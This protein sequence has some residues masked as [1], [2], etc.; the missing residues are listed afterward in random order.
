MT[1][2][3]GLLSLIVA[4]AA[5]LLGAHAVLRRVRTGQAHRDLLL[6]LLLRLAIVSAVVLLAGTARL[7]SPWIMGGAAALALVLLIR[8]GEHRKLPRIRKPDLSSFV[9]VFGALVA[10]RIALQV[11]FFAPHQPDTLAYHL[12]KIGEWIQHR[13]F[14]GEWGIDR[15][16]TFPSGFELVEAWWVVFLRHDVLIE[17]AGIEFLLLAGA[18]TNAM[19][20]ELGLA[21]RAAM[22]AGLFY[23]M[24]PALLLQAVTALNDGPAAALVV[25]TAALVLS[26][27]HPGL[28]LLAVG[29]GVGVKPTYG[30]AL[31]GILLLHVLLPRPSEEKSR[32][33]RWAASAGAAGLAI[34][35]SWY[36][37]NLLQF[38]NPIHP[39]GTEGMQALTGKTL[40]RL[41][42]SLDSLVQNLRRLV[43]TRI[44]DSTLP[45]GAQC[46]MISGWGAV[47][48]ALG[49]VALVLVLREDRRLRQAAIGFGAALVCVLLLVQSDPWYLR[50]TL[51]FPALLAVAV[52]RLLEGCPR[53]ALVTMAALLAQFLGTF[54]PGEMPVGGVRTLAEMGWRV[55]SLDSSPPVETPGDVVGCYG[56]DAIRAYPLYRADFSRR[57]VY[58]RAGSADELMA[59]M[60]RE[61]VRVLLANRVDAAI[62]EAVS[63]GRLR[64]TVGSFYERP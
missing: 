42:P 52:A 58:L 20:R 3:L 8:E 31:P 59:A 4:N 30:Y 57:V 2:M 62:T 33:S 44:Y 26:R 7:F 40:Q 25:A 37:R 48:F 22:W 12:P 53:T 45:Y 16:S 29:L 11:W 46:D 10:L 41:G 60:E 38:G 35:A 13:G 15:R 36:V 50:F 17:M 27:A 49:T 28:I 21:P 51:F 55:R 9:L 32:P 56:G 63:R 47:P 18:A 1:M 14:T 6:F 43:D 34:G 39:V 64:R 61:N 19:A 23:V 5:T 24:T 54:V